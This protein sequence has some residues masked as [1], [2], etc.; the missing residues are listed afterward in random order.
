MRHVLRACPEAAPWLAATPVAAR[1]PAA[2]PAPHHHTTATTTTTTTNPSNPRC[3][4]P[5][6]PSLPACA[7]RLCPSGVG[8]NG[9][10]AGRR[11]PALCVRGAAVWWVAG[12]Q[13]LGRTSTAGRAVCVGVA[14]AQPPA[15]LSPAPQGSLPAPP[16]PMRPGPS[17][18]QSPARRRA[19]LRPA[20]CPAKGYTAHVLGYTVHAVVEA[21]VAV[22][23]P[24]CLD[25]SLLLILPLMEASPA[26]LT[27]A[28]GFRLLPMPLAAAYGRLSRGLRCAAWPGWQGLAALEVRPF[29]ALFLPAA[30]AQGREASYLGL[31]PCC[32]CWPPPAGGPVWRRCRGQG[33]SRVCVGVQGGQEVQGVR[34]R[35]HAAQP[36]PLRCPAPAT[37]RTGDHALS[38]S[39]SRVP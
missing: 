5:L 35:R 27:A 1:A 32:A 13:V 31:H 25:D 26:M 33:G 21:V 20:A 8:L 3:P 23:E 39:F 18:L 29:I 28:P 37:T 11:L 24:G 36:Q 15:G 16:W 38:C 2:P 7:Q 19:S 17:Q 4:P 22:G 34:D 14:W 9:E 30:R 10:A 12:A 6:P